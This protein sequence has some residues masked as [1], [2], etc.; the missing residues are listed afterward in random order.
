VFKPR[1]GVSAQRL[2]AFPPIDG[3]TAGPLRA[4]VLPPPPTGAAL[5]A[6]WS[7]RLDDVD[8]TLAELWFV[9]YRYVGDGQVQG[10]FALSPL[11]HLEVGPAAL[12][13]AGGELTVGDTVVSSSFSPTLEVTIAPVEL[14]EAKGVALLRSVSASLRVDTTVQHL[15]VVQR[16]LPDLTIEGSAH[17]V[18][19]LHVANGELS[20]GTT[21]DVLTSEVLARREGLRVDATAHLRLEV[22]DAGTPELRATS[23]GV[24]RLSP[25]EHEDALAVQLSGVE[26]R[27]TLTGNDLLAG[28]HVARLSALVAEARVVD[29]SAITR[30]VTVYVPV[31]TPLVLRQGPL[32]AHGAFSFSPA[33]T[34][35]RVDRAQLGDA[36]L[37]GAA[38]LGEAGWEGA[39]AGQFGAATFG[40]RRRDGVVAALPFVAPG[41]L[42]AELSRAGVPEGVLGEVAPHLNSSGAR[43]V[44][45]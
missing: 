33:L 42:D 13:L 25:F 32:V 3:V 28:L 41:W 23:A 5:D 17:V 26:A 29:A 40:V 35:A 34:V 43:S 37:T 24:L 9:E 27:C 19:S 12:Q 45:R 22:D 2:D 14:Q 7:V 16:S 36:W 20:A 8:A 30:A 6:I 31:L 18:A 44:G 21:A 10:S 38:R 4:L 1:P 39:A 15:S 11:R